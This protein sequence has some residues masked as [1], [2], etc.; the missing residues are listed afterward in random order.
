[1]AKKKELT[2]VTVTV[3]PPAVVSV[4]LPGLRR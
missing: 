3:P 2:P 1:M 4:R